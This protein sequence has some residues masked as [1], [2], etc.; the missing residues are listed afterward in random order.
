MARGGDAPREHRPS[1]RMVTSRSRSRVEPTGL[2]QDN[3]PT[4]TDDGEKWKVPAPRAFGLAAG[5]QVPGGDLLVWADGISAN[6]S[7]TLFGEQSSEVVG[8]LLVVQD[9]GITDLFSGEEIERL[10][11]TSLQPEIYIVLSIGES[12]CGRLVDG[13]VELDRGEALHAARS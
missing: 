1:L 7:P 3:S 2:D 9:V 5:S 11:G 12:L 8:H 10:P 6:R 13:W 4:T